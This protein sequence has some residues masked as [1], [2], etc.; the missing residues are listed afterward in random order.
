MGISVGF[1]GVVLQPGLV[2]RTRTPSFGY[3]DLILDLIDIPCMVSIRELQ[4]GLC[5][6]CPA[7][8]PGKW[9]I[10]RVIRD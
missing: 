1:G 2:Q 8:Q 5:S 10:L 4:Y 3:T 7:F 6:E 9:K